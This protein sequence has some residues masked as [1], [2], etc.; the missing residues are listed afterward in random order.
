MNLIK[1]KKIFIFLF[2]IVFL[3]FFLSFF[4]AFSAFSIG[5]EVYESTP[6]SLGLIYEENDIS[7]SQSSLSTWW[8]P[9]NSDI[10][11]IMLHGLRSQKADQEILDKIAEF[12]NLGYSIIAVDFRNHGKSGEGDFTFGVDEVND[13]FNTIAYYRDVKDLTRFGIWGFSYGATTALLTGLDFD[14]QNLGVEIV[15]IFAESPY[16]DLLAVFTDQVAYRT[17][18]NTA[19]ANLL[20]PGTVLLSN[21]IYNFEFNSVQEKFDSS[22][23]IGI[24]TILISCGNDEIIPEGQIQ[25]LQT[26]LGINSNIKE[27]NDCR[28]HGEALESNSDKYRSLFS[29]LFDLN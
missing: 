15:G 3:Y 2:V 26:L 6:E 21:L 27:F 4:V 23:G 17:A 10:T 7:T 13:V 20:K 22:S 8:I 5:D 25:D 11:I 12:N 16:M 19:M 1:N 28:N 29:N 9:N 18:L 24:P 14:Q